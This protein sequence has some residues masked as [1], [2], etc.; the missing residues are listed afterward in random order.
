MVDLHGRRML[1]VEDDYF[2][3]RE[4]VRYL[5]GEGAEILG[6]APTIEGALDLIR[7]SSH[8]DAAVLD[9]NL[10]GEMAYPVADELLDRKIPFVFTTGYDPST[11]PKR[12][13]EIVVVQKPFLFEELAKALF[14]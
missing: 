4:L 13:A 9:L 14:P 2:V 3:A 12:Y 6:P 11:I 10:G 8:I 1:V 7:A 5:K